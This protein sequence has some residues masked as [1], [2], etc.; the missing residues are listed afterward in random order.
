MKQSRT[1]VQKLILLPQLT[2]GWL[3]KM[4]HSS[5][6]MLIGALCQ[7]MPI[8]TNACYHY[9]IRTICPRFKQ[10]HHRSTTRFHRF[11]RFLPCHHSPDLARLY[12]LPWP[13][14]PRNRRYRLPYSRTHPLVH[15]VKRL[16]RPPAHHKPM[17][18]GS[19]LPGLS[20]HLSSQHEN[21]RNDV[22]I[23]GTKFALIHHYS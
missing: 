22:E 2:L 15:R 12:L 9:Q 20:H 19:R 17:T 21:R 16:Y 10:Y 11:H 4:Y 8:S 3:L 1:W 5:S 7:S 13:M 18:V 14:V 23:W 6:S